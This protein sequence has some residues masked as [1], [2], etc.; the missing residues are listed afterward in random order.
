MVVR[1]R[2]RSYRVRRGVGVEEEKGEQL[3]NGDDELD[4]LEIEIE[5]LCFKLLALEK[6]VA[7]D[8]RFVASA[9]KTFINKNLERVGDHTAN[10]AEMVVFL[11]RGEDI[12][13]SQ[14]SRRN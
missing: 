11:V 14:G 9:I 5:D 10:I 8:L 12:R 2:L 7:R 1:Q 6:P 3:I 13:H 4:Q